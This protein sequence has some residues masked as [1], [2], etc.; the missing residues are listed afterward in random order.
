M[1]PLALLVWLV[2]IVACVAVAA[3]AVNRLVDRLAI[4]GN[5]LATR[6][7][8]AGLVAVSLYLLV[9]VC[10]LIG[11]RFAARRLGLRW[12]LLVGVVGTVAVRTALA[13]GID[14]PLAGDALA[15]HEEAV[16]IATGG[17]R[18]GDRLIGY[19]TPLGGLYAAFGPHPWLG[20]L[21]NVVVAAIGAVVLFDLLRRSVG[22]SAA[23]TGIG[24]YA[25]MP[26]LALLTPVL[27]S[28]LTYMTLLLVALWLLVALPATTPAWGGWQPPASAWATT[29]AILAG[30]VLGLSQYVR[31]ATFVLLPAFVVTAMVVMRQRRQRRAAGLLVVAFLL[32]LVPAIVENA[33]RNGAM[34]VET[35][36]FGGYTVL[37][38]TNAEASGRFNAVDAATLEELPGD[39][40]RERSDAAGQL[41][42][43]RVLDDPDGF[44]ALVARKL[45]GMWGEEGYGAFLALEANR[46]TPL[47]A[48]FVTAGY[49]SSALMWV[50][51][52]TAAAWGV[53]RTGPRPPAWLVATILLAL[54]LS[55]YHAVVEVQPL[56]HTY[57]A[58][59]WIGAA[60]VGLTRRAAEAPPPAPA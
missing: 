5:E 38:G 19:P 50:L 44:A 15:N 30:V 46:T 37:V 59:L 24:L 32:V 22:A 26:S 39:T 18:L 41:G 57:L 6:Q 13:V 16:A 36:S 12:I 4:V 48:G 9:A 27:T 58:P 42:L 8:L 23:A 54:C 40:V 51:I 35:W 55:A 34:S 7:T 53:V 1:A 43:R 10:W 56:Y 49:V 45:V 25:V 14:V 60:A 47:G 21:F 29:C 31:P 11:L 2:G 20:E 33:T 52:T 17:L 3:S 28:A